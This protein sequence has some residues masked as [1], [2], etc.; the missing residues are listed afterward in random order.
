ML[1]LVFT[2]LDVYR[3]REMED[4]GGGSAGY[5]LPYLIEASG[6]QLGGFFTDRNPRKVLACF[7]TIERTRP[8]LTGFKY[9][10]FLVLLKFDTLS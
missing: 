5:A 1:H 8:S 10:Y 7:T 3:A 6:N 2:G 4:Q 9:A